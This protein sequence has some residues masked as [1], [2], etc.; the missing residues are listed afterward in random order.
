MDGV[1]GKLSAS[2]QFRLSAGLSLAILAVAIIAGIA[3]FVLAFNEAIELQDD[4]LR[5]IAAIV[6]PATAPPVRES[7]AGADIEAR[8]VMQVLPQ[9]GTAAAGPFPPTLVDGMQTIRLRRAGWRV[10]V[11]PA[12]AGARIAV[13][14][15]TALR[16]EIARDSALRTVAP[17][18]LL[19]PILLL[20]VRS[21]IGRM[22]APLQS[23]ASALDQR[24][25]QDLQPIGD[26]GVPAEI[27]P[28]VVAIDRLLARVAQSMAVQRRFVADAAHELRSPMT[29]LSLQAQQ[30]EAIEM[31]APGRQRLAALRSGIQRARE[32]LDQ[33]LAL[34]R[35]QEPP[36]GSAA[37]LSLR[38]AVR[39]VLEDLMPLAQAKDIDIG[40]EGD[41]DAL[42][43]A[44]EADLKTLARNLVDNAIRFTPAGGRIDLRIA[45]FDDVA[46]LQVDDSGPG[47]AKGD[48]ER[49]F[50]PFYRVVGSSET[51][52]GL[53]LSI[54]KAVADRMQATIEFGWTDAQKQLGL[55]VRVDFPLEA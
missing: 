32:L 25:D 16:D 35:V 54:A 29:A 9:A 12:A 47:I 19:A 37:L 23:M 31:Q 5:Q 48:R 7:T 40:I 4:Q 44:H 26:G 2:L 55:S 15:R 18:L 21:L 53:G 20:L 46:R 10:F 49:V 14:Q 1:Q 38:R 41:D 39:E 42:V 17:F 28:F 30:L 43:R 11:R 50:D 52:T 3:S 8:V 27:R 24:R 51:G 34:A 45:A 22:F 33:L 36:Q 6:D 13:G